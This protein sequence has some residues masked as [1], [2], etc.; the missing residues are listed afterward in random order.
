LQRQHAPDL[1]DYVYSIKLLG[2][3]LNR[4]ELVTTFIRK[5][6]FD[7]NPAFAKELL[8]KSPLK[9]FKEVWQS[10][11][12]CAKQAAIAADE[13]ISFYLNDL[14]DLFKVFPDRRFN[15]FEYFGPDLRNPIMEAGR[16]LTCLLITYDSRKRLVEPYSLKYMQRKDG[17]E[18]EYLYVYDRD[19]GKSGPGSKTLVAEKFTSIEATSEKFEPR[20]PVELS[21][22]GEIPDQH[23]FFDPNR[24]A[25]HPSRSSRQSHGGVQYSYQCAICGKTFKRATMNARLNPHKDKRGYPCYGT[26]GVYAGTN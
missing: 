19:G 3:D 4:R 26:Y 16:N 20:W 15:T 12:V 11:I 24:P 8:L 2:G 22:S 23:Y 17:V 13:A 21:K 25:K 9:F 6:I 10:S 7:K 14:N 5:T 18:R 1:F